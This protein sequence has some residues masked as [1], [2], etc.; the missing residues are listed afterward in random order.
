MWHKTAWKNHRQSCLC[1]WSSL[2]FC[3]AFCVITHWHSQDPQVEGHSRGGEGCLLPA[4]EW[5]WGEVLFIF[6]M[7]KRWSDACWHW[8]EESWKSDTRSLS[9][10]VSW[11]AHAPSAPLHGYTIVITCD[12][13]AYRIRKNEITCMATV[14]ALLSIAYARLVA[15]ADWV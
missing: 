1:Y 6:L 3:A 10:V 9:F 12:E 4:E 5:F 11:G 14:T 7:W 8:F 13:Y 15:V 2:I